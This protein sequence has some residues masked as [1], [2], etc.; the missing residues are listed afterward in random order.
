[1]WASGFW[2]G[3]AP[4]ERGE[5]MCWT[6]CE[7]C[8]AMVVEEEVGLVKAEVFAVVVVVVEGLNSNRRYLRESG[9]SYHSS[10]CMCIM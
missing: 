4:G 6:E 2:L 10:D 8:G 7:S 9:W 5:R 3:V 1:M